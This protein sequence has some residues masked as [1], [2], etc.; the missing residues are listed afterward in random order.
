MLFVIPAL[1]TSSSISI[2][3]LSSAVH[4]TKRLGV[5]LTANLD[6]LKKAYHASRHHCVSSTL[7]PFIEYIQA[8]RRRSG[9]QRDSKESILEEDWHLLQPIVT[10]R[11]L[12]KCLKSSNYR[13]PII[14]STLS[15]SS[16]C[17]AAPASY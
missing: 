11:C 17:K 14:A 2:G 4:G 5:E 9:K 15:L 3:C 8:R 7:S 6:L 10:N 13:I 12:V 1:V 16:G